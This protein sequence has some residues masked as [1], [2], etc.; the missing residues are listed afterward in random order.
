MKVLLGLSVWTVYGGV[1]VVGA[2]SESSDTTRK[3]DQT[4]TWAVAGICAVIIIISILLEKIL[5]KVGTWFTEKHKKAL[6]E[7][8]EKVK[9][10]LMI[11][12]FI[13]LLL[14][15]GQSY[16]AKICVPQDVAGTMLPC[17]KEGSEKSSSTEGE[18]RRALLWFDRRFLAGAES[19]VKCKDGY[20]QLISV[21]G[22]HQLHILIF[23]LA[24]FHVLFSVI[25]MTLGRLKSRAWKRW[26]LE[27]LSHDYEFSND[28]SR[29][30]LAH[31]TSFV[32][33][34]TNF[35]SRVPFFFHVGCFFQQFFS[36][37]SRSDYL[38]LRNG[39]IT[40]HL[41]PGSKFNF[42]KYLKRSLEDDF[43]L[44]VG[45]SPVLWASFVIFLL[46]N[47]N[48]WQSLFWAS[49]I[50]VIII[51]AVGTKLQVIMMKM[52]LE[53]KDRHAVVQGMPLVQ[54][55]D[56]YFW[57]GRPQ[58]LLHLIHFALFQNAFQITYFLWIWYSFGLKS[59]F[60]DNFDVVIAKVALGVGAL[61]LCS[62]ITL[63]LYALVTQMGSRMKKSV[64]D[65]QTSKALKKWHMAVKKR[66][67]KGG[68][69]PAR[70]LGSV[71]P[72]VSTVSS[73]HT[74]QRFKTTGHST[75]S[76]YS[77]DDQDVSDLEAEA[78]SPTTATTSF[79][80][81]VDDDHD[82][83]HPTEVNLP[84]YEEEETRNED[85]FSFVKPAP[86]KEP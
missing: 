17:K 3:L 74:L 62:Y 54:G 1:V 82:D 32:R 56:R 2:A 49:I 10:E 11:L 40:V 68:K 34:H 30:R 13:S 19:A 15:F 45:V 16:I 52:A 26:E 66:H 27:T 72:A 69:T 58:L 63:P 14:T 76:S 53:I 50:P 24:I 42:R 21:E 39:F 29:F 38:T 59:C 60:H 37:V 85:D 57:F 64:F 70:T 22:L 31:E 43:K 18:H 9:A 36:S 4:P 7:A 73:S 71:S 33:A 47:V 46:L 44:V 6:F 12:G 28:P 48:G 75:R 5:H 25:T 65:E 51:L 86:P 81:R 67:G 55:S 79:I 84:Q 80:V 41:A 78:L 23:F 8:L 77:Y 83:V 20:E 35:W 61:F